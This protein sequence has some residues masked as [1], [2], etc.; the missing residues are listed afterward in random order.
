MFNA[1]KTHWVVICPFSAQRSVQ[2]PRL[3][4][5]LMETPRDLSQ[6]GPDGRLAVL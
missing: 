2:V 1:W 3:G 4:R 5:A 6:Q